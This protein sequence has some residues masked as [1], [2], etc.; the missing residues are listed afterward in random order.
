M[1]D[2]HMTGLPASE[3]PQDGDI[4]KGKWSR[5]H[6]GKLTSSYLW[7]TSI[8]SFFVE[9]DHTAEA[10][11]FIYSLTIGKKTLLI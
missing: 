8:V 10:L 11:E 2:F 6:Q 4:L 5:P 1:G 3:T 7:A 9:E